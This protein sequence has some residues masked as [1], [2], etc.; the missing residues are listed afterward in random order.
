VPF[1]AT[2]LVAIIIQLS[3]YCYGG[4][5]IKQQS[6]AIAQAVY[7]QINWP[8]MTPKK[9]RLWQMVIMRA[10]RPAKIFGFMFDV[11]LPLLLWVGS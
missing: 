11:D 8:E 1:R 3:S 10:Q 9:R 7:G 5:Y 2:F 6:L 4:E